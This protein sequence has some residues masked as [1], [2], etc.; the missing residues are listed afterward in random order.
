MGRGVGD[1]FYVNKID[2]RSLLGLV[3]PFVGK[4]LSGVFGRNDN[5]PGS[6]FIRFE[7]FLDA[8]RLFVDLIDD[9]PE[10][11]IRLRLKNNIVVSIHEKGDEF[12][13]TE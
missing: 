13:G 7:L 4:H 3:F 8:D 11:S 12:V 2:S 5:H 9:V 10:Y 6:L 1:D